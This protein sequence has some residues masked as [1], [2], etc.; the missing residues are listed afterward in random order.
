ML[1]EIKEE[2]VFSLNITHN[3]GAMA[4]EAGIYKHLWYP[5]EIGITKAMDLIEPLKNAVAVMK[6]NPERFKKFNAPNGWG[7]YDNFVLWIETYTSACELYPNA[8]VSVSR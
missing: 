7:V 5:E 4:K 8:R 3:L 1:T 6:I 2:T